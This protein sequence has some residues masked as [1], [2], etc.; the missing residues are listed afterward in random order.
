MYTAWEKE[1]KEK[2]VAEAKEKADKGMRTKD[3]NA[4]AAI[5]SL[6]ERALCAT[7]KKETKEKEETKAKEK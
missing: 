1:A 5:N 4:W 7:K 3:A 2:E 6:A